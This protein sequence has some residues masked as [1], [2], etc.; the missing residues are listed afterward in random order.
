[1]EDEIFELDQVIE[2]GEDYIII[3]L[4]GIDDIMF[5]DYVLDYYFLHPEEISAKFEAAELINMLIPEV[6]KIRE[7][8]RAIYKDLGFV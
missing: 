7:H 1:M 2:V 4:D 3:R 5:T 6:I 8:K